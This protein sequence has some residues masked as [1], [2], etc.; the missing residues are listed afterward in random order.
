[1][2]K[3]IPTLNEFILNEG[4]QYHKD[5]IKTDN[6]K[7]IPTDF[8]K[9]KDEVGIAKFEKEIEKLGV[10]PKDYHMTVYL[11]KMEHEKDPSKLVTMT[12]KCLFLNKMDN[13]NIIDKRKLVKII[14]DLFSDYNV[15]LMW[16][17]ASGWSMGDAPADWKGFT[18]GLHLNIAKWSATIILNGNW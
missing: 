8:K 13:N 17:K 12:L 5:V 2:K 9:A 3:R 10:E 7:E 15:T 6:P 16:E 1:M 4:N 11:S 18:G 14:K